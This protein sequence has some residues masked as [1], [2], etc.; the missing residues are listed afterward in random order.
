MLCFM[1]PQPQAASRSH[2][3]QDHQQWPETNAEVREVWKH[4]V[5]GIPDIQKER[6]H[7]PSEPTVEAKDR[8]NERRSELF[9]SSLV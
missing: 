3:G 7:G 1:E 2:D 8:Q 5:V 9:H 6:E 4:P